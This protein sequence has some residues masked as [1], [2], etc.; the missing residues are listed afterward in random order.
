MDVILAVSHQFIYQMHMFSTFSN[1]ATSV[2]LA[3]YISSYASHPIIYVE[4][5]IKEASESYDQN[6]LIEMAISLIAIGQV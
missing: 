6:L 1:E 4:R 2:D 3:K 5:N